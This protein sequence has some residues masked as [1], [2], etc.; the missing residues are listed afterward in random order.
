M[1]LV[2]DSSYSGNLYMSD[3]FDSNFV[4][5]LSDV[6]VCRGYKR[7]G[8]TKTYI[9]RSNGTLRKREIT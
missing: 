8:G 5:V 6:V 9:A 2:H 4:L 1:H 7:E 3:S